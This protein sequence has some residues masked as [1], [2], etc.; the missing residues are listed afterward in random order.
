MPMSR[1]LKAYF[2]EDPAQYAERS[3][4]AG[5]VEA[6][7]P[8]LLAGAEF[9]PVDLEKQD[10]ALRQ[11]LCA[12]RRC[13]RLIF[14]PRHNHMS[15]VYAINTRDALLTKAISDFVKAH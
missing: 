12:V 4:Q 2:G 10:S 11:A 7:I 8:L 13:P 6:K 1:N 3:A 14:L 9:D 5:L 15:E